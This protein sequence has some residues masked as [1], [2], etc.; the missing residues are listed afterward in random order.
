VIFELPHPT[1]AERLS[2]WLEG[3]ASPRLAV[4]FFLLTAASA[5][6][7]AYGLATPTAAMLAPF[8]LLVVNVGAAI[9]VHRRF[10]TDL[11]LLLF[12][13]ALLALVALAALAR[14]IYME[15]TTSLTSGD[16]FDGHLL[17]ERR[18]PLHV[19]RL[20]ELH[21]ANDGFVEDRAARHRLHATYNRVRWQ[22]DAGRWHPAQIGDD[23][24][25]LLKGYRIYTSDHRGFSPL[26]HWRTAAGGDEYGSVQLND[27]V[28]GAVAPVKEFALPHGP[29][30]WLMLDFEASAA[31][32]RQTR[33]E[34]LGGLRPHALVL[35]AGEARHVLRPGQ[36]VELAGGTLTYVRLDSWMGYVLSYDPTRP[37]IMATVAIGVFSLIWFYWRRLFGR[38]PAPGAK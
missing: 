19:G 2:A 38:K 10:R 9:V 3:L 23:R 21:F 4:A 37:W 26:L 22:D 24:P 28:D 32:P 8:A 29:T 35:R 16:A 30:V 27:Q 18:G 12:H 5:L 25:L 20:A 17:T 7:A 6:A 14:L 33:A 15:G 34:L 13:L 1:I 36:S 31:A 11:P